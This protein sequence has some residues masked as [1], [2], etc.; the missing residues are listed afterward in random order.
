MIRTLQYIK[1]TNVMGGEV[2]LMCNGRE[3]HCPLQIP[4]ES[5]ELKVFFIQPEDGFGKDYDQMALPW[6]DK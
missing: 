3:M 5:D 1:L 2:V 4:I 6:G